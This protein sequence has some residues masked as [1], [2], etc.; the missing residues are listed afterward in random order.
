VTIFFY[1]IIIKLYW[2][3]LIYINLIIRLSVDR[4]Q[5]LTKLHTFYVSNAKTE[6][7]YTARDMNVIND[8]EFYQ[9]VRNSIYQNINDEI[10]EELEI[11][12]ESDDNAEDDLVDIEDYEKFRNE[13]NNVLQTQNYFN[14]VSKELVELL[15]LQEPRV[16]IEPVDVDHVI[17]HGN[18]DFD[19]EKLVDQQFG[20]K[21]END[22][23]NEDFIY[24]DD[25]A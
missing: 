24:E 15:K 25:D 10:E 3:K 11:E 16:I 8:E 6:L 4:L 1:Y 23:N 14:F 20:N 9:S 21:E 22:D 17:D 5:N 19:L 7:K 13:D 18:K 12:D 2:P